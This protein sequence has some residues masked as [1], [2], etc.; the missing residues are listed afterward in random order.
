MLP[1]AIYLLQIIVGLLSIES[2]DGETECIHSHSREVKPDTNLKIP[3]SA[4]TILKLSG[5]QFLHG[6]MNHRFG[7]SRKTHQLVARA[8]QFSAFIL[9]IGTMTDGSTLDPKDAIIVQNKVCFN[10]SHTLSFYEYPCAN[11]HNPNLN[12]LG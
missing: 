1:F 2:K 6:Y 7:T 8:R 5:Q 4:A 3:L 11:V 9:V 12:L 10:L